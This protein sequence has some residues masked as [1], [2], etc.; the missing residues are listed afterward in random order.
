MRKWQ[1]IKSKEKASGKRTRYIKR[2]KGPGI[3]V[4]LIPPNARRT[5]HAFHVRTGG[6]GGGREKSNVFAGKQTKQ[7]CPKGHLRCL[8]K[9]SRQHAK[10]NKRG[11][12]KN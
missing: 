5:L 7:L 11:N 4:T 6:I 8:W 2:E 1:R 10:A 9:K 3:L 12:G